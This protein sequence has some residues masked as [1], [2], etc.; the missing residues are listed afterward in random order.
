MQFFKWFM[1]HPWK[2]WGKTS[3]LFCPCCCCS[4][5]PDEW[6]TLELNHALKNRPFMYSIISTRTPVDLYNIYI[7]IYKIT[8]IRNYWV[9]NLPWGHCQAKTNRCGWASYEDWNS[10]CPASREHFALGFAPFFLTGAKNGKGSMDSDNSYVFFFSLR[11]SE[12]ISQNQ[13]SQF[14]S[15]GLAVPGPPK[16]H[17]WMPWR[18]TRYFCTRLF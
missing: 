14:L 11:Y 8:F 10:S 7:Y 15:L 13:K 4:G 3:W 9:S 1:E 5:H 2:N 12:N 16:W 6:L 17:L 18:L